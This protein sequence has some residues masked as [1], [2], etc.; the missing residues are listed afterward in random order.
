MKT[1]MVFMTIAGRI[2][3]ILKIKTPDFPVIALL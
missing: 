2:L 3:D 1:V